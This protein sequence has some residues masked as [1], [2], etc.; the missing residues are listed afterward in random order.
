[1]LTMKNEFKLNLSRKLKTLYS[2]D[3]SY[4]KITLFETINILGSH[5]TNATVPKFKRFIVQFRGNN[6]FRG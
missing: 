5:I 1:M 4:I 3:L 2:E 6:K